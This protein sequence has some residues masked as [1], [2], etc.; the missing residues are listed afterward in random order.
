LD[1]ADDGWRSGAVHAHALIIGDMMPARFALVS[2]I[3]LALQGTSC[4]AAD[5]TA[6]K[7]ACLSAS[8]TR[9]VV[10]AKK[11]ST[12]FLAL[13]AAGAHAHG[14]TL[15][16]RLCKINDDLMYEVNVL[17]RDGR[18]VKVILDAATG[19]VVRSLNDR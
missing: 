11:L 8:E 16:M 18:V 17:R 3:V 4:V 1:R 12:P 7:R 5:Q 9:E 14:E 10:S 13:R 2:G 19:K 15:G 6:P